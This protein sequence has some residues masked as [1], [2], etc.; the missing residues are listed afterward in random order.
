MWCWTDI[1]QVTSL[2]GTTP[3]AAQMAQAQGS[4]ELFTDVCPDPDLLPEDLKPLDRRALENAFVYQAAWLS[5]QVDFFGGVDTKSVSQD[6]ASAEY[7]HENATKLAP[8]AWRAIRNLSWNRAGE[9]KTRTGRKV[10]EDMAAIEAAFLQDD[11]DV[12]AAFGGYQRV[13]GRPFA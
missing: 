4:L 1:A 13:P 11:P 9:I 2:T 10:F 6:G 3:T 8:L 5:K 7:A 12:N